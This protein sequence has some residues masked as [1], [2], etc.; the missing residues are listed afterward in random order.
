MSGYFL[1]T[2]V[3]AAILK[4]SSLTHSHQEVRTV[5]GHDNEV[6]CMRESL[7]NP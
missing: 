3:T 7:T 6:I 2:F 1:Q 5:K 4:Q